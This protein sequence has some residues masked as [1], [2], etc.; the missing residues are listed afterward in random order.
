MAWK[1]DKVREMEILF[2]LSVLIASFFGTVTGFG[3]ATILIPI[4]G[5]FFV[6][7]QVLLLVGI[8][9]F[10]NDIWRI[11]LFRHGANWKL[12]IFFG[13]PGL[14]AS[15]LAARAVI[16][17]D[18]ELLARSLG[19]FL[20]A[21]AVWTW[22]KPKWSLPRSNAV[23]IGGGLAAGV[24]SGIL[25]VGGAI[26]AAFLNAFRLKQAVFLFTAGVIGLLVD[27]ARIAGYYQDKVLLPISLPLLLLAIGTSFLG[28]ILA[29]KMVTKIPPQLFHR[30]VTVFLFLIGLRYLLFTL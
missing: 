28:A 21:T 24:L 6:F 13:V 9:H 22:I 19:V 5:L 1:L 2:L 11:A 17:I 4:L 16:Q 26:R 23:L 18:S 10:F 30:L 20:V 14:I 29:K 25:G 8:V 3:L 15:Y 12:I 27:T 7:P